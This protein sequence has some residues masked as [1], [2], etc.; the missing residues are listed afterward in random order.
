METHVESARDTE[1]SSAQT[2]RAEELSGA[3]PVACV[4]AAD[5]CGAM[6]VAELADTLS[7]D[8]NLVGLAHT[9]VAADRARWVSLSKYP[10]NQ[11]KGA[12]HWH[13]CDVAHAAWTEW[14]NALMTRELQ[15]GDRRALAAK[16]CSL[17]NRD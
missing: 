2:A 17:V 4:T 5:S 10:Y 7:D 14:I 16:L 11:H 12:A 1:Q 6:S 15:V 9:F 13:L 3:I 8:A